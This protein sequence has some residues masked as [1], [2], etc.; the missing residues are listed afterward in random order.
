[1][2]GNCSFNDVWLHKPVFKEWLWRVE[3]QQRKARCNACSK[4]FD[5]GN[6]G[7]AALTSHMDGKKTQT[8]DGHKKKINPA[9]L[10]DSS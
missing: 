7:E 4:E 2:P 10:M 9:V 1:M 8:V 6:M 3:G 5:I